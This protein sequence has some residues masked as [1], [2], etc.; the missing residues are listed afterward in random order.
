MVDSLPKL[1]ASPSK[2][3]IDCL[4][5]QER[6]AALEAGRDEVLTRLPGIL[7]Q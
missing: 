7:A 2:L 5:A 4:D 6:T 3:C 1:L